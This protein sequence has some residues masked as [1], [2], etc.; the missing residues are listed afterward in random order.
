[1]PPYRDRTAE[2]QPYGEATQIPDAQLET[3]HADRGDGIPERDY[4]AGDDRDTDI[5]QTC[6]RAILRTEGQCRFCLE[7]DVSVPDSTSAPHEQSLHGIVCLLVTSQSSRGAVANG[8]AAARLLQRSHSSPIDECTLIAALEQ[9]I[10]EPLRTRCGHLP[11]VVPATGSRADGFVAKARSV[12][13]WSASPSAES[14]FSRWYDAAGTQIT[15]DSRRERLLS[16]SETWVVP[17]I[18]L[19]QASADTSSSQSSSSSPTRQRLR[20]QSCGKQ[21]PHWFDSRDDSPPAAWAGEPVWQ[22]SVCRTPQ[23]GPD[24]DS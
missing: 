24:P 16:D 19:R 14:S 5:C 3:D 6:G 1:M 23:Y 9:S 11:D 15:E 18:A 8:T 21:T 7:Q 17:A 12:S 2:F 4:P 10:A 22:C 20:C 13:L